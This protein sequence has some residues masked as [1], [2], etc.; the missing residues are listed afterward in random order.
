MLSEEEPRWVDGIGPPLRQI[1]EDCEATLDREP[2]GEPSD[3]SD[4][5]ALIAEVE[6]LDASLAAREE[7]EALQAENEKLREALKLLGDIHPSKTGDWA[8]AAY[9]DDRER[10]MIEFARQAL[11]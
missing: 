7:T 10:G 6:K 11:A 3:E 8:F 2:K 1:K 5:L 9:A 4:I